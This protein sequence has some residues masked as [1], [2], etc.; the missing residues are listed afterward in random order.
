ME[1][2]S[3]GS[4]T[5]QTHS[6]NRTRS[7]PAIWYRVRADLRG[8]RVQ[9]ASVAVSVALATLLIGLG[10]VISGSA[11]APYDRLF[12][13]LNGAHLWIY[14]LKP[15]TPGQLD[16]IVHAPGVVGATAQEE[17]ATRGGILVGTQTLGADIRSYPAQTPAIGKLA[18]TAGQGL[19]TDDPTG[20]VVDQ[21]FA[22]MHHLHP[23]SAGRPVTQQE[24][25][26]AHG[27]G[28]AINRKYHTTPDRLRAPGQLQPATLH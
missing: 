5:M 6:T 24:D 27:G 22:A 26:A 12:A 9:T 28:A 17:T 18:I 11:S 3:G 7:G 25:R 19:A 23:G 1:G 2:E 15:L 20:I 8:R 10:L 4:H 21:A 16:A 14:T 13:Q